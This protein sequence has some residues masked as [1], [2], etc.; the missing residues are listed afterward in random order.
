MATCGH[1]IPRRAAVKLLSFVWFGVHRWLI[2]LVKICCIIGFNF[3]LKI[4]FWLLE[5]SPKALNDWVDKVMLWLLVLWFWCFRYKYF[6]KK[7]WPS[8]KLICLETGLLWL[9]LWNCRQSRYQSGSWQISPCQEKW[10][11]LELLWIWGEISI[12]FVLI[13]FPQVQ[14]R[15]QGVSTKYKHLTVFPVIIRR[16]SP[17]HFSPSLRRYETATH[18]LPPLPSTDMS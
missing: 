14:C 6:L 8:W 10:E 5:W 4:S 16:S 15:V 12:L 2:S 18:P 11:I 9:K 13:R 17:P 7:S 1:P 3:V